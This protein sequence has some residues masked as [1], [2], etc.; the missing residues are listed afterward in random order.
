MDKIPMH[1]R[2][3][4]WFTS[5]ALWELIKYLVG[6][7][8]SAGI[9]SIGV[10]RIFNAAVGTALNI[11]LILMG[12]MGALWITGV[13]RLPRRSTQQEETETKWEV[14]FLSQDI[15]VTL[16][17]SIGRMVIILNI[18]ST[19]ATELIFV[20]TNLRNSKGAN[21][22]CDDSE[23]MTVAPMQVVMKIIDKKFPPQELTRFEKG[24]M[25]SLDGYAKF[26]DGNNSIKTFPIRMTVIPSM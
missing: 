5:H 18:L 6:A 12:C 2:G 7:A 17:P 26:R 8:V 16:T 25:I 15:P 13:V 11:F 10:Q 14:F 24:D 23:P 4:E 3:L 21:L 1:K 9:L 20:H 22:D 19:K